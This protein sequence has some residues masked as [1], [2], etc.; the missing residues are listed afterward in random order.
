[1]KKGNNFKALLFFGLLSMIYSCSPSLKNEAT[2]KIIKVNNKWQS[3]HDVLKQKSF[4]HPATYHIGNL[5]AYQVIKNKEYLNYST[6]WAENNQWSGAKSKDPQQWKFSYGEKD[7]YVLFGD[8]QACFQVYIDLYNISPEAYKISRA[9]EVM[10][11]QVNTNESKY[12]W[13][14]DGLFMVMP[15]MPRMYELTKDEIYLKKLHEYYSFTL[16]EV[17]DQETGLLYRD[18]KYIYPKHKTKNGIK[19]FWARGNGWVF[20]ALARTLDKLPQTDPH[21]NE[22]VQVFTKM[23]ETLKKTQ[24][25]EG[26]WTRS[27]L[28]PEQ[29]PGPETSGTSFFTYGMLW[30]INHKILDKD[31]YEPIAL[32]GWKYLS[33]TAVQKDGT[34]GFIQP[35]GER[36]VPGQIVDANSTADFGV[37]AFLLAATELIKYS[38]QIKTGAKD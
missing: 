22:Y 7:D 26:Y 29:A 10:D 33:Q 1:M 3:E 8:W 2:K 17:Y 14:I 34:L 20:A 23:A 32:N 12:W 28:D 30:G 38:D 18:A 4:W 27:I 9:K 25:K 31:N 36:A 37:G 35:I 21:Y 11:Y 13:W 5:E 16:K 6:K 19:D 15:V 24:Q